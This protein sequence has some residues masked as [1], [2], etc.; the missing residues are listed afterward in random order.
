MRQFGLIGKTLSHSFSQKYF[1]SKFGNEGLDDHFY[2][3]FEL[4]DIQ[5]IQPLLNDG[6]IHGLNVTIPYK[7]AVIPYLHALDP[8]AERIGAVNVIAFRDG[9]PVGYNSDYIG[10]RSSL[11]AWMGTTLK[12]VRALVLG[13]GGAS[14]AVRVALEDIGVPYQLVSRNPE[15]DEISYL[16]VDDDAIR[17]HHLII[18]TTPLGMAPDSGTFPD[19]P[20]QAM[21][22]NH[23]LYDLVYNPETT[24]FMRKGQK[25]GARTMNGLEMLYLQADAAW[26]IWNE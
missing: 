10:F 3:L 12:G 7:T 6:T 18:N 15:G 11:E 22:P 23:Y 1:T 13:T 8:R 17:E 2:R 25:A 24:M 26:R 19:I 21:G 16:A 5:E 20:Y 14:R 9:N 4:E